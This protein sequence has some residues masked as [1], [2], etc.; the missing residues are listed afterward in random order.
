MLSKNSLLIIKKIAM[1][2]KILLLTIALTCF[3]CNKSDDKDDI[4]PK[5]LQVIIDEN[6]SNPQTLIGKI[7]T[8]LYNNEEVFLFTPREDTADV[9]TVV[10]NSACEGICEFGG[11][12]GLNTCPDFFETAE[13]IRIVWE[14]P[15]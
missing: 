5:C 2:I 11:I 4:I 7:E 12:A 10:L 15:G 13:F 3:S 8:Y 1:K 14:N 9:P 6:I